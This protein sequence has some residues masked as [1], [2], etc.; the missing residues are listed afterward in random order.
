MYKK[1]T[2]F[3]LAI[4]KMCDDIESYK[5]EYKDLNKLLKTRIGQNA[6]LMNISQIGEYSGK[7]SQEF[8]DEFCDV[9][10]K[11][12]KFLRNIIIHDYLGVDLEKIKMIIKTNVPELVNDIMVILKKLLISG[13]INEQLLSASSK[14]FKT[15][16]FIKF[17]ITL[18][19]NNDQQ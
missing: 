19:G 14:D 1:D 10:W 11:K 16:S 17:G 5:I 3:L 12:I 2:G 7:L 6:C 13:R 4:L 8:T 9:E 15:I 18:R